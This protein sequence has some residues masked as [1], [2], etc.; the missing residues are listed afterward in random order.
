MF[1]ANIFGPLNGYTTTFPLEVF[2]QRNS[3]A[4][5]IRLKLNLIFKKTKI[6]L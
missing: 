2:T 4:D 3:L 1:R 6:A 5:F